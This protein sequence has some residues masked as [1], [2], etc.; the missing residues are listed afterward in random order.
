MRVGASIGMALSADGNEAADEILAN[1]DIAMYRAKG[2][3]RG[4]YELFDE[5]M[6][7]W[8]TTQVALEA[9]LRHAVPR[10]ELQLFCQPFVAADTGRIRGFEALLRW[11]RPGFG[12][13]SPDEFIP[14]AEEAGLMLDI[15]SWVLEE[16]C[17]QAVEW[18]RRWPEENL[19]IAVN[20][21][22]RQILTG[23]VARRSSRGA[24]ERTGLRPEMLTLELTESTLMD[25]TV[26][27]EGLLHELRHLG[28]N[29]SLDDFGT[30]Y[31][32]LTYL[33]TF[34]INIVKID[35]S[36]VRAIGTDD[37][38]T[39]VMAAVISF[40][41]HLDL[42]VVAEGIENDEQLRVML[43]LGCPYLQGYLFS[44]P[45]PIDEVDDLVVSAHFGRHLRLIP[46]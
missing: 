1:A 9:A 25:D 2:N 15:G 8:V 33:R 41:K 46:E 11:N 5:A 21:S 44:Q 17:R 27:V 3:G 16:A 32:S 22:S 28:V 26:G 10:N 43:D 35:R 7:E 37:E 20:L 24:L 34:P 14:M 36:F 6:Q 31:S 13:V 12:L 40:A 30:G 39:A 38:D 4:R 42:R 23:D 19:G 29:L 45:R 18:D